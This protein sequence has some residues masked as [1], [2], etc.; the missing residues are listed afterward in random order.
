MKNIILIGFF[1]VGTHSLGKRAAE[2]LNVDFVDID[3]FI[4]KKFQE[5]DDYED[6]VFIKFLK[7]NIFRKHEKSFFE[8]EYYCFK[9]VLN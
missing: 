7:D 3:E 4:L 9:R 8:K 1:M 6:I 2:I 5:I